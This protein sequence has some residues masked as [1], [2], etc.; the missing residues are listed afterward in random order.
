MKLRL[1]GDYVRA[2]MAFKNWPIILYSRFIAQ[3][4]D[5][6]IFKHRSG[7]ALLCRA[8]TVD[9]CEIKDQVMMPIY[10]RVFTEIIKL[11]VNSTVLDLGANVGGFSLR[12]AQANA[13]CKVVAYEPDPSNQ[14]VFRFNMWLNN[15]LRGRIELIPK[16]VAH[17]EGTAVFN[18]NAI[19]PAG[20]SLVA[21][22]PECTKTSVG[23]ENLE[24]V[25]AACASTS[26]VVKMDIEGSEFEIV[27]TL[28]GNIWSHVRCLAME[29]HPSPGNMSDEIV[30]KLGSNGFVLVERCGADFFFS[31]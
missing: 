21:Y 11:P 2:V 8:R 23:V 28:P 17:Y 19:N 29:I 25:L 13:R 9:W 6:A 1:L 24:A 22:G 20:S 27:R 15:H 10:R 14:E 31:R 12:A 16:A 26:I 4:G 18:C 3:K 30:R 7:L 5:P